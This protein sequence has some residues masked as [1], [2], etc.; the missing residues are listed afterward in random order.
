MCQTEEEPLVR[1]YAKQGLKAVTTSRQ[2]HCGHL[3][4]QKQVAA[5]LW[6]TDGF[7]LWFLFLHTV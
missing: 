6:H 1:T 2:F 5:I 7:A 3:L 4:Q